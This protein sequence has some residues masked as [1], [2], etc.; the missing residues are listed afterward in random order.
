MRLWLAAPDW[1]FQF[2][3]AGFFFTYVALRAQD[4]FDPN[5]LNKVPHYV[6][7]DGRAIRMVW[8]PMLID[9]TYLLI[10]LG[11]CLRFPARN[12]ADNGW[13]VGYTMLTAYGPLIPIWL[14]PF[15]GLIG[16]EWQLAYNQFLWRNP[17]T[18][19]DILAGGGLLTVG[20]AIE[21]WG[22]IVLTRSI[23][24]VPEPRQLKTTGPYRFVR[25][26]IYFGQF[27]AQAG[28]WLFFARWHVMWL[29]LFALFIAMQL[30][31]SKLE[32]RVL[33]EAFGEEC[34]EWQRR[35]FWFV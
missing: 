2:A 20:L 7:A 17:V 21:V 9:I 5:F 4:Y 11:Y 3:G 24:I 32:D 10:G 13:V 30:Y 1:L 26:P 8:I 23:S 16:E 19:T 12:R 27:I 18:L 33:A 14:S 29:S 35:T 28:M 25:H 34:R 15:L 22:Y 31:R 6:W